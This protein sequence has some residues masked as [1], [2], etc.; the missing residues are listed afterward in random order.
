[1][2]EYFRVVTGKLLPQL[3]VCGSSI[4]ENKRVSTAGVLTYA[5]GT[6]H[7]L[8]VLESQRSAHAHSYWTLHALLCGDVMGGGQGVNKTTGSLEHVR[9]AC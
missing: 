2:R 9:R 8:C 5:G 7:V 4:A 6:C 1:M 3:T